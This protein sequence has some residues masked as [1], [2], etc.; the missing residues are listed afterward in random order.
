MA[1]ELLKLAIHNA[2]QVNKRT[3]S[4]N[5][6]LCSLLNLHTFHVFTRPL[7][8]KKY[9]LAPDSQ[10]LFICY[11]YSRSLA[12]NETEYGRSVGGA[13]RR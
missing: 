3:T 11:Y 4:M 7:R 10:A 13:W 2:N 12:Q 8:K 5:R 1:K 6:P 9:A